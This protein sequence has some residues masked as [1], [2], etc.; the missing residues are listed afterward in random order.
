MELP[1]RHQPFQRSVETEE[2]ERIIPVERRRSKSRR[3]LLEQNAG[4]AIACRIIFDEL[5]IAFRVESELIRLHQLLP[6]WT[7]HSQHHRT[8]SI[9]A[10]RVVA[11]ERQS[12][13][14]AVR[15]DVLGPAGN[16][17]VAA[18]AHDARDDLRK[19]RDRI[20]L[21]VAGK[22]ESVRPIEELIL[23]KHICVPCDDDAVVHRDSRGRLLCVSNGYREFRSARANWRARDRAA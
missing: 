10:N 5:A 22:Q 15:A 11:R 1:H 6:R 19:R 12:R 17:A 3:R 13:Q 14:E 23:L 8:A 9:G 18:G 2:I 4:P 16:C 7:D 21:A 20:V